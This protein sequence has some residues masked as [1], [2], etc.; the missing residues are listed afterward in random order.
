MEN[1][2]EHTVHLGMDARKNGM[3]NWFEIDDR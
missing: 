2:C 3:R 1:R